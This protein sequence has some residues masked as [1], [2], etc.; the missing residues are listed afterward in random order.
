MQEM[1]W[2][3]CW[4]YDPCLPKA[5]YGQAYRVSINEV[6]KHNIPLIPPAGYELLHFVAPFGMSIETTFKYVN[7]DVVVYNSTQGSLVIQ[8]RKNVITVPTQISNITVREELVVLRKAMYQC[9][10]DVA[11]Q[12]LWDIPYVLFASF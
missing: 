9:D 3:H 10:Q 6:S 2:S 8:G 4:R 12:P 7:G 5:F 1:A 11:R